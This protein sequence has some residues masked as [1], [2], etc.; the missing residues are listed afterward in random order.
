[1]NKFDGYGEFKW[2]PLN[3]Q[4]QQHSYEGYW[5]NGKMEGGGEFRNAFGG[6]LKGL[7]KNNQCKEQHTSYEL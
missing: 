4:W 5:K 7:F 2:A 6:V 3:D 1:M